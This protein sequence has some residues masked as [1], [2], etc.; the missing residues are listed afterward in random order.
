MFTFVTIILGSFMLAGVHATPLPPL[1]PL[2]RRATAFSANQL[3]SLVPFAQFAR[4]AYCPPAKI[5]G[6]KCGQACSALPGFQA[7]L[8]GGNGNSQQFFFVGH[9]PQQ[10][11]VV[12]AH[13]GTNPSQLKSVL[14]DVEVPR[15][16]LNPALF[17]GV[18]GNVAAHKGFSEQHATAS[19]QIFAEVKRLIAQKGAKQVITVGHS[20]GGALAILSALSIRL[21]LPANIAVTSTTFGAPRVGNKEFANF[22]DSKISSLSRVNNKNDIVPIIPGRHL[23]FVHPKGEIH[24]LAKGQAVACAGQDNTSDK[25]CQVMTVPNILKGNVADHSGPYEGVSIGNSFCV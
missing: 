3:S 14:T 10:N 19:T 7:T 18:P 24:L 17:P 9:W 1:A 4:A 22:F 23:G 21:Q 20:L 15:G 13:Q 16:P 5:T 12:V 25:Q 2:Q 8:T 6:W 11:A